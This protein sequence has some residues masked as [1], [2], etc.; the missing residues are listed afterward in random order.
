MI[1]LDMNNGEA[2]VLAAALQVVELNDQETTQGLL[3]KRLE[4]QLPSSVRKNKDERREIFFRFLNQAAATWMAACFEITLPKA[5]QL[6]SQALNR[7]KNDKTT[8]DN[9]PN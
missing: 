7:P 9:R 4:M 3:L 8:Q 2:L 5:V 6:L 1:R